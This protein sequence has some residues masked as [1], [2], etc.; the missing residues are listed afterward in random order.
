MEN[1]HVV[2]EAEVE[3]EPCN[4]N[5]TKDVIIFVFIGIVISSMYVLV[6][7]ML[8]TTI[9]ASEDIEKIAGVTVLASIPIYE[10]ALEERSKSRRRG[11]R[12]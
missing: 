1:V 11:G 10:T 2:D 9:K 8:D 4:I 5:H 7:N 6:I 12:R 3:E